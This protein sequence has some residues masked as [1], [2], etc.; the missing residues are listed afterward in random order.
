MS[1]KYFKLETDKPLKNVFARSHTQ[2]KPRLHCLLMRTLPYDFSVKY[3]KVS[4]SQLVDRLSRHAQ[5]EDR[6][7]LSI[8][9]VHEIS[10]RLQTTASRIELLHEAT[11]QDD[12]LCFLKQIVQ[13]R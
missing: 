2:A 4:T 7:T 10:S 9:Q 1:G 8:V 3:V 11:V 6:I 5:L 13:D 12:D